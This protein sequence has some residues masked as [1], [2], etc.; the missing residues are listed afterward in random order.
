MGEYEMAGCRGKVV[1]ASYGA[2]DRIQKRRARD[3]KFVKGNVYRCRVCRGFHIG[4]GG[5]DRERS[6]EMLRYI[7]KYENRV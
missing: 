7:A 1:F 2:A 6:K 5:R 4:S 3:R